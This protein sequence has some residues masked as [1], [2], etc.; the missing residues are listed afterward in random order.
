MTDSLCGKK[1]EIIKK[2]GITD[3]ILEM[4]CSTGDS[5]S[6][7]VMTGH[8]V[9]GIDMDDEKLFIAKNRG[10][11][12]LKLDLNN[13][14]PLNHES[15]S[16]IFAFDIMEHLNNPGNL[17]KEAYRILKK[18][19]KFY[20]SVPYFGLLKRIFIS[21]FK[22]DMVFGY[23]DPHIRFFSENMFRKILEDNDFKVEK[24]YKLG[25]VYPFYK[26]MMA[27]CRKGS[28]RVNIKKLR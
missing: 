13:N 18:G 16:T 24:I 26:N 8:N 22:F 19:G 27:I 12:I 23:E 14:L 9:T 21:I 17:V 10:I 15:Y 2:H 4:G 6:E 5:S 1:L 3:N 11:K 20:A 7:F 28:R 25:R